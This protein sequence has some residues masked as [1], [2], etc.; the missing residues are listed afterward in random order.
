MAL[1]K[2]I[3]ATMA[4]PPQQIDKAPHQRGHSYYPHPKCQPPDM[5]PGV[6]P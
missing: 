3:G 5:P 4:T 2:S 6:L 1:V